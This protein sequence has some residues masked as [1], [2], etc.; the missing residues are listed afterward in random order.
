MSSQSGEQLDRTKTR[1]AAQRKLGAIQTIL[2][3]I[4]DEL[5]DHDREAGKKRDQVIAF[6]LLV[7]VALLGAWEKITPIRSIALATVWIAG[8]IS[9]LI[10]I[11]YRAWH[12]THG[13]A[14]VTLQRLMLEPEPLTLDHCRE[15]WDRTNDTKLGWGVFWRFSARCA[16]LRAG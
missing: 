15:L 11:H 3:A 6:Y 16:E 8:L 9:F 5:H 4:Y 10:V 2:S 7:L 1:E 12:V 14:M 13:A